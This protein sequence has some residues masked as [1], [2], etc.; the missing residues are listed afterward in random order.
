MGN[1][2]SDMHADIAAL[3]KELQE[4][5]ALKHNSPR[6]AN[7]IEAMET[8]IARMKNSVKYFQKGVIKL[9]RSD[10]VIGNGNGNRARGCC[11]WFIENFLM[12]ISCFG[13][14]LG[15]ENVRSPLIMERMIGSINIASDI[16]GLG[17]KSFL[18]W[19]NHHDLDQSD[20]EWESTLMRLK[21]GLI[22][23]GIRLSH[24]LLDFFFLASEQGDNMAIFD[25][26]RNILG[27]RIHGDYRTLVVVKKVL[28]LVEMAERVATYLKNKGKEISKEEI[29]TDSVKQAEDLSTTLQI[30]SAGRS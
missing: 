6:I 25:D 13:M 20:K 27:S 5:K 12:I 11:D 28:K 21:E 18:K 30:F 17:K 24:Q 7:R 4:M 23:L 8:V 3:E 1:K 26:F 2:V 14:S 29:S 10:G 16:E 15:E 19:L 9:S 22:L